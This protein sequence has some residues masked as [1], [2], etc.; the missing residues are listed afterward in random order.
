MQREI[1]ITGFHTG[2]RLNEIVNDWKNA[3]LNTRIITVGD[4]NFTTKG[5]NQRYVPISGELYNLLLQKH[6]NRK[7]FKL[8]N[9]YIFCKENGELYTGS[10]FSKVFKKACRA[11]G[12]NN[13]IHFHSLRHSFASNLVQNEVSL[14][15]IKELLGTS[16]TTTKFTRT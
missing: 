6:S 10:Y 9:D 2:L 14:Y 15:T 1:I 8:N 3:N 7:I 12:I 11:A 16:I 5:R 13:A 4:E